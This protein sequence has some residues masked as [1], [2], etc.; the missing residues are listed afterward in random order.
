MNSRASAIDLK[1]VFRV[2]TWNALSLNGTG[3]QT[4]I[5][6]SRYGIAV[7]GLTEARLTGS[8]QGKVDGCTRG[9]TTAPRVLHWYCRRP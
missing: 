5:E 1:K 2:A 4:A 9:A 6:L 7:A 3:Y 8:D